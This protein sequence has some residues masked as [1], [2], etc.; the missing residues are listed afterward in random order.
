MRERKGERERERTGINERE[1]RRESERQRERERK[2]E[3]YMTTSTIVY[4]SHKSNEY[5]RLLSCNH[6]HQ[7]RCSFMEPEKY[8]SGIGESS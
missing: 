7:R 8:I 1:E 2:R 3:T 4:K 5:C 6:I